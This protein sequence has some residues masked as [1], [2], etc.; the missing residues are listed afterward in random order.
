MNLPR[1]LGPW[2]KYL[3]IFPQE[4][5]LA[6]TPMI[7]RLSAAIGPL[8][9]ETLQ[10]AGEPDGFGGLQRRGNY[11]RLLSGEWLLADE[12]PDEFNRR[13]VMGEH[14]F[15][16]LNRRE[17]ASARASMALF[18]A[19]PNQLGSPRIAHI[20]ALIVLARRAETAGA[21]F[22]WGILQ[23]PEMKILSGVSS[24]EVMNLINAGRVIEVTGD[25]LDDWL[26]RIVKR[27]NLDDV[28][29]IGGKR[30]QR[31]SHVTGRSLVCV[32]DVLD[33]AQHRVS[34]AVRPAKSPVRE[35]TLDLPDHK[36][37]ARLLRDP[38]EDVKAAH[39]RI[40]KEQTPVSNLVFGLRGK[41]L[42]ARSYG[43]GILAYAVPN[44]PLERMSPPKYYSPTGREIVAAIG[45]LGKS[46]TLITVRDRIIRLEYK[47][48]EYPGLSAGGYIRVN[49]GDDFATPSIAGFLQPCLGLGLNVSCG[50]ELDALVLDQNR[51]MFLLQA[52]TGSAYTMHARNRVGVA[53][54]IAKDVL[55][56]APLREE[57]IVIARASAS[58]NWSLMKIARGT[59]FEN[60][61][62]LGRLTKAVWG[63]APERLGYNGNL[64]FA[65][66]KEDGF[67]KTGNIFGHLPV[68]FPPRKGVV[69]VGFFHR[70]G[71]GPGLLALEDDQM[72]LS[73]TDEV[74]TVHLPPASAPIAHAAAS[75]FGPIVA[76]STI[77]GEIVI[78]SL[79]TGRQ[80]CSYLP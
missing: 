24:A 20:A 78:Y 64:I 39:V 44:S 37:C 3:D 54:V 12:F 41:K 50:S 8:A 56:V 53:N 67:W 26:S 77:E 80:L 5:A 57:A 16:Q 47:G 29:L 45:R 75:Y 70:D 74:R 25:H 30:L 21:I 40:R 46:T 31:L 27:Q 61:L 38:F 71:G 19:G 49:I 43:G 23:Q 72:T 58:L 15:L 22:E 69:G 36:A 65:I 33:P 34:I 35:L 60:R 76:Y 59:E 13:S 1:P 79:A 63:Y 52:G 4:L 28:W 55:A 14:L 62:V 32:S 68:V 66:E 7:Q 48:K 2:A 17:P 11:E 9:A 42:Y 10:L 51:T 73:L 18:D 6:L